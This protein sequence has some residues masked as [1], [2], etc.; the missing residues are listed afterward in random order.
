V[1]AVAIAICLRRYRRRES[2]A[3][4]EPSDAMLM[5]TV[6]SDESHQAGAS[7]DDFLRGSGVCAWGIGSALEPAPNAEA[8]AKR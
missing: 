6:A 3:Y 1:L 4:R 8:P 7:A 2:A 5:K